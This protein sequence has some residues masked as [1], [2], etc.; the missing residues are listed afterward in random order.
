[1]TKDVS[2]LLSSLLDLQDV[3]E[4]MN[5]K[6]QDQ[7]TNAKQPSYH[8]YYLLYNIASL[9]HQQQHQ[10]EEEDDKKC[11][12]ILLFLFHHIHHIDND[13]FIMKICFLLLEVLLSRSMFSDKTLMTEGNYDRSMSVED[14]ISEVIKTSESVD[15]L[16]STTSDLSSK[17]NNNKN[18][19]NNKE[20][21]LLIMK[22]II[23]FL[24]FLYKCRYNILLQLPKQAKKEIKNALEIYQREIRKYSEEDVAQAYLCLHNLLPLSMS[25]DSYD[26]KFLQGQSHHISIMDRLN[27]MALYLKVIFS[28]LY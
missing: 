22:Q 9:L 12:R 6:D 21:M 5:Q 3:D 28:Y 23:T 4:V 7:K 2:T 26:D 10:Q 19:N 24:L 11:L 17:M 1:M 25:K 8:Y 15:I 16:S 14:M 20:M 13:L 27:Q 18:N